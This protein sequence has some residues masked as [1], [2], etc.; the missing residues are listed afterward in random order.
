MCGVVVKMDFF[1]CIHK[2]ITW[3]RIFYTSRV[4]K[5]QMVFAACT[6]DITTLMVDCSLFSFSISPKF[7]PN[8]IFLLFQFWSESVPNG[9]TT[10]S[11][12]SNAICNLQMCWI[13]SKI[14]QQ[15]NISW[16][17]KMEDSIEKNCVAISLSSGKIKEIEK[18]KGEWKET[19][20]NRDNLLGWKWRW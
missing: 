3:N 20:T 6:N 2:S 14:T 5:T 8:R 16:K 10:A 19:T 9:H 11:S 1:S 15:M 7:P 17:T 13:Y 12:L 4:A 18:T